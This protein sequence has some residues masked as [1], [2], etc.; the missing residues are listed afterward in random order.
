MRKNL[1]NTI[2]ALSGVSQTYF[3]TATVSN[4]R[5]AEIVA[6]AWAETLSRHLIVH[7]P[8]TF[9]RNPNN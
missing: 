1:Q 7:Q 2:H 8:S 4:E 3:L 5:V 6:A 9:H